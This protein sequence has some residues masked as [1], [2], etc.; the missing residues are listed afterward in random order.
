MLHGDNPGFPE[1]AQNAVHVDNGQPEVIGDFLLRHPQLK[2][3]TICHLCLMQSAAQ[4]RQQGSDPLVGAALAQSCHPVV[5]PP[6]VLGELKHDPHAD[7][8]IL[9][10]KLQQALVIDRMHAGIGQALDRVW[11]T[12]EQHALNAHEVTGQ[13]DAAPLGS[14]AGEPLLRAT[15]AAAGFGRVRRVDVPAP[16]NLVLELR[17]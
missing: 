4:I 6:L 13:E 14:Q 10:D 3:A 8:M 17:P 2:S 1:P 5:Q 15:A 16:M 7:R 12:F 11:L 9:R